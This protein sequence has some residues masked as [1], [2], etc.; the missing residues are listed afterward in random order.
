M[1]QF[2]YG[3]FDLKMKGL[4]FFISSIGEQI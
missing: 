4:Q 3:F 1:Q 2:K